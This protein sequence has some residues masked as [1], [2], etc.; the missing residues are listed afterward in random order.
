LRVYQK[1]VVWKTQFRS[2]SVISI[3]GLAV[4]LAVAINAKS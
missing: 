1:I 3:G 2:K 4:K